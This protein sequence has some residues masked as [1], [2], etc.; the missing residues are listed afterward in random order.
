VEAALATTDGVSGASGA[1]AASERPWYA[2]GLRFAC[3]QCGNCC[4]GAPGAVWFTPEEAERMAAA[5]RIDLDEFY[6]RYTRRVGARRSLRELKIDGRFDC[7]FLDRDRVPGKAVCSLYGARP[8][9]C[10]TW[11]WW[12]EVVESRESWDE[13]KRRTPCPGMGQGPLHP[14]VEITIGLTGGE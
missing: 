11:P 13:T 8:S 2:D 5:L 9:Q 3:T 1:D 12:P 6:D 4:S 10:R 7:V 14:L